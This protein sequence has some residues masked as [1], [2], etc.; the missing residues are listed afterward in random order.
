MA[1]SLKKGQGV[2]LKKSENDLSQVTI[3]LG[4]DVAEEYVFVDKVVERKKSGITGLF[5][6]TEQVIEKEKVQVE[7]DLDAVAFL[8]DVNG[9]V[10]DF[11]K[12]GKNGGPS[13][14]DG[15]VIFYNSLKH[16]SG[17]I[18]LTGD[19]RTGEGDGDDEQIIVN[20]DQLPERFKKVLFVVQIYKGIELNQN[21][22]KVS[23]AFICPCQTLSQFNS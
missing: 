4:W 22:S 7:Y 2:S 14:V 13:L 20:L 23:N 10:A 15:D 21:F 17:S 3:G 18:W 11:G 6:A 5:G 12:P 9:K 19:N 1:I 16:K 8:L